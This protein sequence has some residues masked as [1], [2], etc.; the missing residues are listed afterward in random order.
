MRNNA[1]RASCDRSAKRT[2]RAA[3]AGNEQRK[4]TKIH[5]STTIACVLGPSGLVAEEERVAAVRLITAIQV[6]EIKD[7][8]PSLSAVG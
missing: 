3:T 5:R 8:A 4:A 1:R 7:N 2:R 6:N